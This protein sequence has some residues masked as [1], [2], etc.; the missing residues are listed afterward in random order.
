MHQIVP[1]GKIEVSNRKY[2]I[3]YTKI[4][5]L[6]LW[7]DKTR[8]NDYRYKVYAKNI[9]KYTAVYFED[10]GHIPSKYE[11]LIAKIDLHN[12]EHIRALLAYLEEHILMK[13]TAEAI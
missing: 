9:R 11:L 12:Q 5:V 2:H 13:L 4:G 6:L 7:L 10:D 3:R 8:Y 1:I